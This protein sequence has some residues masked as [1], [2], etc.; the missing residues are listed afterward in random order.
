MQSIYIEE[1]K[2]ES[3][4]SDGD[5]RSA[6]V[7]LNGCLTE[8]AHIGDGNHFIRSGIVNDRHN[9]FTFHITRRGIKTACWQATSS[10]S[11]MNCYISYVPITHFTV[12]AEGSRPS[13]VKL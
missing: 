2:S 3:P 5:N 9:A 7:R 6:C 4:P 1:P 10:L 11:S 8:T 12:H 13:L